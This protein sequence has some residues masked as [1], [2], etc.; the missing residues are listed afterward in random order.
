VESLLT[1]L[2]PAPGEL[3]AVPIDGKTLRGSRK[4]DAPAVH[5]LS[6]LTH[7]LGLALWQQAVADKSHR[8]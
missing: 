6:G 2:P 8:S 3:E 1:A 5:L 4:P 7:R